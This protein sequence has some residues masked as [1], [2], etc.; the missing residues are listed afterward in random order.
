MMRNSPRDFNFHSLATEMSARI[1]TQ[2]LTLGEENR[3]RLFDNKVLKRISE[4]ER[5]KSGN[6]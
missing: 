1:V 4:T 3:L 2:P 6:K 5:E